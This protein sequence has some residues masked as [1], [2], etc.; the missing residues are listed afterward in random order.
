MFGISFSVFKNPSACS[1]ALPPKNLQDFLRGWLDCKISCNLCSIYGHVYFVWL[2]IFGICDCLFHYEGAVVGSSGDVFSGAG[3]LQMRQNIALLERTSPISREDI[4]IYF[5]KT[6]YF[7]ILPNLMLRQ[8]SVAFHLFGPWISGSVTTPGWIAQ[9]AR[10]LS[11][12]PEA[13][14]SSPHCAFQENNQPRCPWA[15]CAPSQCE[16]SP[17]FRVDLTAHKDVDWLV[18]KWV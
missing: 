2:V 5:L 16:R 6:C 9:W 1:L 11:V 7:N 10:S 17:W 3:A 12:E 18:L 13:G 15:N 14:S 8:F 4:L